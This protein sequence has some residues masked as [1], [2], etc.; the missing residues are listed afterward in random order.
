MRS[1]QTRA[2]RE[3]KTKKKSFSNPLHERC[4][5]VKVGTDVLMRKNG[6]S[7][8]WNVMQDI[9]QLLD[10]ETLKALLIT[11][12]AVACGRMLVGKGMFNEMEEIKQKRI[13]AA[14]GNPLLFQMWQ[15]FFEKKRVLQGLITQDFLTSQKAKELVELLLS[16]LESG[17]VI[18]VINENDLLSDEELKIIRRGVF[19]DNDRTAAMLAELLIQHYSP[20]LIYLTSSPGVLDKDGKT[21]TLL[22]L[23]EFS[24]ENIAKICNGKSAHGFGGMMNKLKIIKELL[25]KYPSLAVYIL[26]GKDVQQ[27]ARVVESKEP[28]LGTKVV[29]GE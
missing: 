14:I 1:A 24:E 4:F 17:A 7:L 13:L 3:I 28:T 16:T 8:D 22:N 25:A 2:S 29:W 11:S 20:T 23:R 18:P 15:H 6:A 19:G 5:I 9:A 12:G 21:I 27:L 10:D 26:P